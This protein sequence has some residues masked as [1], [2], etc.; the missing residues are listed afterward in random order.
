MLNVK[1]LRKL[2][3]DKDVSNVEMRGVIGDISNTAWHNKLNYN[4]KFS[5][6]QIQQIIEYLG[7]KYE[8]ITFETLAE[9]EEEVEEAHKESEHNDTLNP[10]Y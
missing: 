4:S 1:K 10:Q 6:T 2:M 3:I 9:Y 7:C 5:S 8:D